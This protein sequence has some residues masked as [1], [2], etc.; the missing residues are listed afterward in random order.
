MNR[1]LNLRQRIL[2]GYLVPL[3]LMAGVALAV[4][5][6]T[7]RLRALS[8][9]TV[10]AGRIV[11]L[12]KEAHVG[13]AQYQRDMRGYLVSRE[14]EALEAATKNM[15]RA[16]ANLEALGATLSGAESRE[17]LASLLKVVDDMTGI[18]GGYRE[19]VDAGSFA[20]AVQFFRQ[21]DLASLSARVDAQ[22]D[23]IEER[24]LEVL[25]QRTAEQ[26]SAGRTLVSVALGATVAAF[27]LALA[28]GRTLAIRSTRTISE[29]VAHVSTAS[30]EMAATVDEHERT[31]AQQVAA[32]SEVSATVEEL[33][34]SARQSASQAESSAAAAM[35]ALELARQGTRAADEAA[36][37]TAGMKDK[38]DSLAHRILSLS[39]QAG[40]IGGIA[41]LVGEL[42]S[43]TNMLA[44][45]AAVEAARAGEQG[46]GFAVV[47]GEIR[48]LAVQSKKSAERADALVTDIQSATNSAVMV[49]E[50]GSRS[51][52]EVMATASRVA[53]AFEAIAGAANNVSENAQQ[54]MLNSKQQA[55][56]LGQVTDAM[57]SLA[58]GSRQM[59]A[60]TEQTKVGIENLRQVAL[61]LKAMV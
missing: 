13:I 32:V 12:A 22:I 44:L 49:T 51:A 20:K 7:Q 33:G 43:E 47:A 35:Q 24:E 26:V 10:E 56:A 8:A 18:A 21:S 29:S 59:A 46:K 58:A 55:A 57:Q 16:R 28:I 2:A 41:K 37:C 40:Q 9:E 3:V 50:D 53:E 36:Q 31:V 11:A 39:E 60:G 6:Q 27:V 48:K 1:S 19:L 42:A 61:G 54:V 5:V 30:T 34:M 17:A 45:N 14:R 25:A 15:A 23:R 4:Y 38:I 52:D